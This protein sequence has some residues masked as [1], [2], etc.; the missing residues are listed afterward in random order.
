MNNMPYREKENL[1]KLMLIKGGQFQKISF[2]GG[3]EWVTG[4]GGYSVC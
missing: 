1:K 4:T 3:S 2:G